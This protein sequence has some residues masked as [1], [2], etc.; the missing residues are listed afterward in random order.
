MT[1]SARRLALLALLGITAGCSKPRAKVQLSGKVTFNGAPVPSG[2]VSFM[3]DASQ[4]N[5]GE[6]VV[7][8]IKEGVYDSSREPKPGLYPGPTVIRIAGFD[9]KPIPPLYPIGKQIFNPHEVR[10]V[11]AAG[12]KDFD[13]PA[14]AAHN[15]II[16][17]TADP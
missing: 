1:R 7:V 2:Y 11:V 9:G 6:V 16:H 5:T 12:T 15:L 10:E 14:S 3:P 4:G 17:P 13:V 8:P